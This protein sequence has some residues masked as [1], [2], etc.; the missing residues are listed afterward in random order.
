MSTKP[1]ACPL[2]VTPLQASSKQQEGSNLQYNSA[3]SLDTRLCYQNS[4]PTN[5]RRQGWA[6]YRPPT[7]SAKPSP[8]VCATELR[9]R[10]RALYNASASS[11]H[12]NKNEKEGP[13]SRRSKK[14]HKIFPYCREVR[15]GDE[16]Q[17]MHQR[18]SVFRSDKRK[19]GSVSL[20]MCACQLLSFVV[21][22]SNTPHSA[23]A[24][25]PS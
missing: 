2:S 7:T 19:K 10:P 1:P 23:D 4:N 6:L 12:P 8:P 16:H 13:K 3:A 20:S 14:R 17:R 11:P 5:A 24:L 9:F 25:L 15:V 22:A 21:L 18:L